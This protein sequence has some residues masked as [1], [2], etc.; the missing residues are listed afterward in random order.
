[1]LLYLHFAETQWLLKTIMGGWIIGMKIIKG[2]GLMGYEIETDYTIP[3]VTSALKIWFR[4]Y[5]ELHTLPYQGKMVMERRCLLDALLKLNH[6]SLLS[7]E[8]RHS[9]IITGRGLND[10]QPGCIHLQR[11]MEFQHNLRIFFKGN[12]SSKHPVLRCFN[13][14]SVLKLAKINKKRPRL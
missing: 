11:R 9:V 13:S 6:I 5:L 7:S 3:K 12:S 4:F 14:I 2:L 8:D 10:A 1:M